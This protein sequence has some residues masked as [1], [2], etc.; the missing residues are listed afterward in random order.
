MFP[1]Y[2]WQPFNS[3]HYLF[4]IKLDNPQELVSSQTSR[5]SASLAD[6][7]VSKSG[8]CT[9]PKAASGGRWAKYQLDKYQNT[10]LPLYSPPSV[11]VA[12]KFLKTVGRIRTH[13]QLPPR[14]PKASPEPVGD[15]PVTTRGVH[16]LPERKMICHGCH[17]IIGAG[18]HKGSATG[19]ENCILLHSATCPG[20]IAENASWRPC[21]QNYLPG[22]VSSDT[23]F[24]Q[25]LGM[26][27][28]QAAGGL[29]SS[30]PAVVS[31][32]VTLVPSNFPGRSIL[33]SLPHQPSQGHVTP[34]LGPQHQHQE[35][36]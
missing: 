4:S 10:S 5:T 34:I 33:S 26:S 17:G 21:P 3:F 24:E 13:L 31:Q 9:T 11:E 15:T 28:F 6:G 20:D 12:K 23:G 1:R 2:T 27:D 14:P 22:L 7:L 25:T 32:A 36:S 16:Q 35:S 30:T 18:L 29:Q 8:S 19:K